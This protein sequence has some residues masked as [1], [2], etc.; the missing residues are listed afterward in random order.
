MVFVVLDCRGG[1]VVVVVCLV[2]ARNAPGDG[3][4]LLLKDSLSLFF[5]VANGFLLAVVGCAAV[6]V[7]LAIFSPSKLSGCLASDL[8]SFDSLVVAGPLVAGDLVTFLGTSVLTCDS[9][10]FFKS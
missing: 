3:V 7:F 4:V 10:R 6:V 9:K 2:V 1:F 8:R 5:P